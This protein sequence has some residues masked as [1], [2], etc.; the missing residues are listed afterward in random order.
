MAAKTICPITREQFKTQAKA[1][2]V[3][4][5]DVP[6]VAQAKEFSTGSLGW[7]ISNKISVAVGDTEVMVQMSLNIT[8]VGS[9]DLPGATAPK[10]ATA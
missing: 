4:I 10:D 5:N 9:K 8:I 2:K 3:V 1:M 7:G 6:M